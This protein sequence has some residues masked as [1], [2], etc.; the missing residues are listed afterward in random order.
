MITIKDVA[1]ACGISVSTASRAIRGSG[2][3]SEEIKQKVDEAR[4]ELGYV[5]NSFAQKL[6]H[7]RH[8]CIGIVISDINNQFYSLIIEKLINFFEPLGYDTIITYSFEDPKR[9]RNNFFTLLKSGVNAIIFTP[10]S[11]DNLDLIEI[12]KKR[13]VILLQ[14][15]RS[16]FPDVASVLIDDAYGAYLATK[17]LIDLGKKNILLVSVDLKHTPHRSVGYKKALEEN[18][19]SFNVDNIVKFRPNTLINE[20]ISSIIDRLK[21]DGIIAGTNTFGL[22]IIEVMKTRNEKIQMVIFDDMPW[23]KMLEIPSIRQPIEKVVD[24]ISTFV[25]DCLENKMPSSI[26]IVITPDI[27]IR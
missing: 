18:N 10:V 19:L 26:D 27:V 17:H 8:K 12:A 5:P 15:F 24:A 2:Y 21:P 9:E 1:K 20:E 22:A 25:T 6:K 4:I 23:A 7:N 16:A 11:D 13:N 3:V 14:I